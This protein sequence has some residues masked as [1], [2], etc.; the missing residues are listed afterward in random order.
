LG[1]NGWLETGSEIGPEGETL[2]SGFMKSFVFGI[3]G[4]YPRRNLLHFA[5][6]ARQR[7]GTLLGWPCNLCG[8]LSKSNVA[9]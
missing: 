2:D 7:P 9:N 6:P 5:V 4:S 8:R 3:A 1:L